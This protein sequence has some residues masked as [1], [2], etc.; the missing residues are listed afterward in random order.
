[1]ASRIAAFLP[2]S[3]V[4]VFSSI[5][6][7]PASIPSM[8]RPCSA[9]GTRP[10]VDST[11]VRPPTQSSIGKRAMNPCSTANLSSFEPTPV[12]ATACFP[13]SMPAFSNVAFASSIPL[14][15]SGVPPDFEITSTSVS[16]SSSV[17]SVSSMPCG[18]V[19]SKNAM[20]ILAFWPMAW[21][22]S[23]GPSAE[24]PMPMSRICLNGA[25]FAARTAPVWT[26]P[27]NSFSALSGSVIAAFS[28]G[29]GA[30]SALR[31]Q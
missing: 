9:A 26:L 1:M 6:A 7:A 24:P 3:L 2:A 11:D 25:P 16:A 12:T 21:V 15:V 29:V 8:S 14:R 22:T 18:S 30:R 4:R 5:A 10:T 23:C 19:L 28:S 17:A 13:K 27:A 31:S 20:G